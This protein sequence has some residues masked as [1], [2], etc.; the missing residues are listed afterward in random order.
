LS[1]P[2]VPAKVLSLSDLPTFTIVRAIRWFAEFMTY[3]LTSRLRASW[4]EENG[5]E[6]S[7]GFGEVHET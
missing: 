5:N 2:R 7:Q 4:I 3:A 6:G 1:F